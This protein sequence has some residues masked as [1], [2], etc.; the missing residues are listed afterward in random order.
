MQIKIQAAPKKER[1]TRVRENLRRGY[2]I[3]RLFE[4]E[5]EMNYWLDSGYRN[6]DGA[7]YRHGGNTAVMV[8]GAIMRKKE[9]AIDQDT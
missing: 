4:Y 6:R 8:Y 5:K 2:M 7:K 1:L 9:E 3:V